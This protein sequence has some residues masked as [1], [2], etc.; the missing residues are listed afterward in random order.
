MK[1]I[2]DNKEYDVVVIKKNNKNTYMRVKDDLTIYIT[3]SMFTTKKDILKML[4][5]NQ[6]SLRKM[7]NHSLKRQEKNSKF[8]Y[9]GHEYDII[10]VPTVD[11]IDIDFEH[12]NIY[13]KNQIMVDKWYK[14]EIKRLFEFYFDKCFKTFDESTKKPMLKI[15]KMK[16][17]WGVYNRR[18]HSVTLNSHLI[19]YDSEKLV[20][21]IFH[22]LSHIIHFDH[23]SSFWNLVSKYCPDYKR[24]RKELKE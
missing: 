15:R 7:I 20:Y 5:R 21:V 9:L 24:I 18:N 1:Y 19:E 12:Y 22:E 3:T 11:N 6:V 8:F 16:S 17:R 23:S 4:N 13:T 14:K 2:L 10:I